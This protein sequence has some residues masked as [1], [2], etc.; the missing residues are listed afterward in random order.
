MSS[1]DKNA[2]LSLAIRKNLKKRK[3]LQKK[4]KKKNK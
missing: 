1:K 3:I 2:R 4:N